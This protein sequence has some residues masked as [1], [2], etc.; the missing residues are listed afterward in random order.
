TAIE[1][2]PHVTMSGIYGV[3]GKLHSGERLTARERAIHDSAGCGVL[4]DLHERLDKAV[5]AAYGW[6]WPLDREEVLRRLVE[7]Q[8]VRISE[9][10]AGLIRWIRP[11][12]QSD[13]YVAP[14]G[15]E[16]ELPEEPE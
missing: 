13:G 15:P 9:E 1:R 3:I 16:L 11:D 5:A 2:D 14:E 8:R 7:L 4:K 12:F 6:E 10:A